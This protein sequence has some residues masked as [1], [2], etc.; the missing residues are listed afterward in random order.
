MTPVKGVPTAKQIRWLFIL[1]FLASCNWVS[2]RI[3]PDAGN[4]DLC[5]GDCHSQNFKNFSSG[6]IHVEV[7]PQRQ[8]SQ[9]FYQVDPKSLKNNPLVL[10][11]MV[12]V[13]GRAEGTEPYWAR[14][15]KL[16]DENIRADFFDLI[17]I[18]KK[19]H[20]YS[21][22][23]RMPVAT[24]RLKQDGSFVLS[25]TADLSYTLILNPSGSYGRAPLYLHQSIE[26]DSDNFIFNLNRKMPELKGRLLIEETN[27]QGRDI[28]N[29]LQ[30]KL[31]QGQRLVS[32]VQGIGSDGRFAVE[33]SQPLFALSHE[34]PIV[35]SIEPK[36]SDIPLPKIS[37]KL[38]KVDLSNDLD[39]GDIPLGLPKNLCLLTIK[40][41]GSDGSIPSNGTLYL[42]AQ[43]GDGEVLIKQ[44]LDN[45]GIMEL[46]NVYEGRY[47]IAVVPP[48]DSEFSMHVM[49]DVKID[50]QKNNLLHIDLPRRNVLQAVVKDFLG[51]GV[52]GASIEFA[53]IGEAGFFATEDIYEDML[54]KLA[55]TTNNE[56]KVCHRKFGFET[57]SSNDCSTLLLDEGRYLAHIIP[58]AGSELA[59]KWMFIDFPAQN[60]LVLTLD[61]PYILEGRI[62]WPDKKP[63]SRAFVTLYLAEMNAYN[64]PKVIGFALTDEQGTFKAFVSSF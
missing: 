17:A 30:V 6:K 13:S 62:E 44:P 54:F 47:D 60:Q 8:L 20:F 3:E 7:E 31:L 33:I 49:K 42:S 57:S 28:L 43:M 39:V 48:F 50:D 16:V 52:N 35:L 56:G 19:E 10:K 25:L 34:V 18:P 22:S 15:E 58:P 21:Y 53:R 59:H 2:P 41:R 37:K 46:S 4:L 27:A 9:V 36:S 26:K 55:A 11:E 45:S 51:Q 14:E 29:S 12:F 40:V 24:T 64:Q 1:F 23:L 32:S 5:S 38:E 61:S 63:V